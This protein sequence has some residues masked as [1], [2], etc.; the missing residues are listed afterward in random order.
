[1]VITEHTRLLNLHANGVTTIADIDIIEYLHYIRHTL[2]ECAK[3]K[4]DHLQ[5]GWEEQFLDAAISCQ[6]TIE[7]Y[8]RALNF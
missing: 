1:M 7:L 8:E 6:E 5:I 3:Q 4:V 2:L